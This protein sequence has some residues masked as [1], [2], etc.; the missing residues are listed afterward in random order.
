VLLT[1]RVGIYLR[2]SVTKY[3]LFILERGGYGKV[4]KIKTGEAK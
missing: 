2:S 3:R 1:I 4:D